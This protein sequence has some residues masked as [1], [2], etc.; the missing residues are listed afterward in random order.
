MFCVGDASWAV[1]LVDRG[2]GSLR[3]TQDFERRPL[4]VKDMIWHATNKHDSFKSIE[5]YVARQDVAVVVLLLRWTS[6]SFSNVA[7]ICKR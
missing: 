3:R 5:P 7:D 6:H 1:D 2:E 4:G